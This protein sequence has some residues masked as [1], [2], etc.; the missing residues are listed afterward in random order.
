MAAAKGLFDICTCASIPDALL[1][2]SEA[3]DRDGIQGEDP[4]FSN[5]NVAAG[6]V[7]LAC[8]RLSLPSSCFAP[9]RS[10][11][12][13]EVQLCKAAAAAA[14]AAAAEA[15]IPVGCGDEGDHY[16]QAFCA[17]AFVEEEAAAAAAAGGGA[18]A[19]RPP[20]PT[21]EA[22]HAAFGGALLPELKFKV[23]PLQRRVQELI[24]EGQEE[25]EGAGNSNAKAEQMLAIEAALKN[26]GVS[27]ISFFRALEG[28]DRG[29]RGGCVFPLFV[30][31]CTAAGS[32]CGV[33]GL[34]VWT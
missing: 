34:T 5:A 12:K 7:A 24:A 14:A 3:M 25:E 23:E 18:K 26:A 22:L 6:S 33:A 30:L 20:V 11:A 8:G 15:D 10:H 17:P 2:W 29:E 31:G 13:A 16:W 4:E 32:L 19:K 28:R 27:S 9:G 1:P 21:E